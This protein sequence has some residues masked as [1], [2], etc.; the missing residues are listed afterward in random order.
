MSY[1]YNKNI[2][3]GKF[4]IKVD[5]QHQ[6]GCFEHDNYGEDL[7]GGLWFEGNVLVDYDG[8]FELPEE[9]AEGLKELG[10]NVDEI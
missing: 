6:Y 9:V 3:K 7:G 2:K 1:N 10:F 8:V 5:S 4:E